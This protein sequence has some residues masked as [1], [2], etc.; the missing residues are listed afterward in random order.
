VPLFYLPL[1]F[2]ALWRSCRFLAGVNRL[3]M[4]YVNSK[5]FSRNA[6][7]GIYK[8]KVNF[9]GNKV[10]KQVFGSFIFNGL[11]FDDCA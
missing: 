5:T 4:S 9:C 11:A 2:N 3:L 6:V 8:Q 10:T 1:K 7:K